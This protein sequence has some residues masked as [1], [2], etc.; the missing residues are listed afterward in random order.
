MKKIITIHFLLTIRKIQLKWG[1]KCRKKSAN[2]TATAARET[3]ETPEMHLFKAKILNRCRI[4]KDRIYFYTLK[5]NLGYI[6]D[7]FKQ[8]LLTNP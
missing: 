8:V 3:E 1:I 5:Q 2:P 4:F 7:L 6:N